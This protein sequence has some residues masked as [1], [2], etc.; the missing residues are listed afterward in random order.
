MEFSFFFFFL[1]VED[2]NFTIKKLHQRFFPLNFHTDFYKTLPVFWKQLQCFSYYTLAVALLKQ[3]WF[4][5]LKKLTLPLSNQLFRGVKL[6]NQRKVGTFLGKSQRW[7]AALIEIQR[8]VSKTRLWHSR[9]LW[10][11]AVL[12]QPPC[13]LL[14]HVT[15]ERKGRVTPKIPQRKHAS[16]K[17]KYIRGNR[18]SF[19]IKELSK[20]IM[21]TSKVRN[22]F[23]W[24]RSNEIRKKY[25][26]P[27]GYCL[28]VEKNENAL[29]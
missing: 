25:S 23:L 20:A 5:L 11:F 28:F 22:N 24:H 14:E 8:S 21:H 15:K 16:V 10:A 2:C 27:R 9:P 12:E 4:G 6:L 29:L 26:K 3:S 13:S 17:K 19:M 1:E 18:L 7:S